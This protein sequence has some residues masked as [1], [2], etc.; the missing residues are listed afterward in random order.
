MRKLFLFSVLLLLIFSCSQQSGTKTGGNTTVADY[1]NY[2]DSGVQSAGIKMI[3]VKT[4]A[5]KGRIEGPNN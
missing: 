1:F 5:G 4:P 3:P 2:G